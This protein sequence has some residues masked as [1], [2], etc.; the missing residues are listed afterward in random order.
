[1]FRQGATS[2]IR[3]TPR[4]LSRRMNEYESTAWQ[5]YR[6]RPG[7][8]GNVAGHLFG[9]G[10][11]LRGSSANEP[12][13][14]GVFPK[15][16]VAPGDEITVTITLSAYGE[17]WVSYLGNLPQGFSF[18]PAPRLGRRRAFVRPNG[19]QVA[20]S[21]CYGAGVTNQL[22]LQGRQLPLNHGGPFTFQV[23]SSTQVGNQCGDWD[24]GRRLHGNRGCGC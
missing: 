23:T 12:S 7:L 15:T 10:C 22:Y 16:T 24:I 18:V 4:G 5:T 21:Y 9:N 11:L 19:N 8:A 2:S 13:A 3:S 17:G 6:P 1:M 14:T 20:G